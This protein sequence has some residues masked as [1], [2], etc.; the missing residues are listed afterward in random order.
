M[1]RL[2]FAALLIVVS[3]W[4][5]FLCREL[6]RNSVG[7]GALP[8]DSSYINVA[9]WMAWTVLF[10]P[11]VVAGVVMARSTLRKIGALDQFVFWL[12]DRAGRPDA[13]LVKSK[14]NDASGPRGERSDP[15]GLESLTPETVERLQRAGS[16]AA[17]IL[18][19][20]VGIT[21]LGIGIFGLVYLLFFSQLSGGSSVYAS[22]ATVKL[23]ML[24]GLL[25]FLGL[26][27]LQ[28][29]FRRDNSS[30]LFP[31]RLFTQIIARRRLDESARLAGQHLPD[32]KQPPRV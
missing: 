31:L 24:S 3:I 29:T 28:R 32:K 19:G 12:W 7:P 22:L 18:G 26:V 10:G 20:L 30:W 11:L 21:W 9:A 17:T 5:F 1:F 25:V 14:Q 13:L 4:G 6:L 23:E 15:H 27:V 16:R 8:V 2:A